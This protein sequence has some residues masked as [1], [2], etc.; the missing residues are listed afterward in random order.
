MRSRIKIKNVLV[1]MCIFNFSFF[2]ERVKVA[3]V[4]VVYVRI[5]INREDSI[6][7]HITL[8]PTNKIK[9]CIKPGICYDKPPTSLS[10]WLVIT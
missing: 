6:P 7:N 3:F 8:I 10:F 4:F 5:I 1:F 9:C 2:I